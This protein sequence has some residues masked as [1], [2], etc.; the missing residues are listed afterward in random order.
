VDAALLDRIREFHTRSRRTY[1]SPRIHKDLVVEGGAIGHKRHHSDQG[2]QYTSYAFERRCPR[3][4]PC[5]RRWPRS[6]TPSRVLKN[7]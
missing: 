6:A 7:A 2:C 3:D 5:G 1:G 4:G